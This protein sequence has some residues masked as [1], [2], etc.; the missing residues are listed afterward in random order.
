[1]FLSID[2]ILTYAETVS[3]ELPPLSLCELFVAYYT[4]VC[5]E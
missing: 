4:S 5:V 3:E 2:E 1:M